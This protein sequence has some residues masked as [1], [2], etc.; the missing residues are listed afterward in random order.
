MPYG[1]AFYSQHCKVFKQAAFSVPVF[2]TVPEVLKQDLQSGKGA[3]AL[4]AVKLLLRLGFPGYSS[5]RI[6]SHL[7]TESHVSA[8]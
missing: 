2:P 7:C 6:A 1:H 8:V 3:L 4:L 5:L